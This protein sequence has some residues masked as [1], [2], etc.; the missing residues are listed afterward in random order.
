MDRR[1]VLAGL[2]VLPASSLVAERGPSTLP[3]APPPQPDEANQTPR[4][5]AS[6]RLVP[7]G[8]VTSRAD[9]Q[10]IENLDVDARAG[11]AVTVLHQNVTGEDTA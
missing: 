5:V 3:Q 1:H 6:L 8:P 2:L 11:D 7:S 4:R 10:L 9:G